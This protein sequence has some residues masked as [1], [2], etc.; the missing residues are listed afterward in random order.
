MNIKAIKL[1]KRRNGKSLVLLDDHKPGERTETLPF[2]SIEPGVAVQVKYHG[3]RISLRITKA[4]GYEFVGRIL[5]LENSDEKFE[6][7]GIDDYIIFQEK[8]IFSIN[9]L[10]EE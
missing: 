4:A 6:D 5:T 10:S 8:N 3:Q 7:L 1:E 9:P 2:I